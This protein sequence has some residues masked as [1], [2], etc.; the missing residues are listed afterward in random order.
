MELP[1]LI[2]SLSTADQGRNRNVF[3]VCAAE[4]NDVHTDLVWGDF[5]NC[6]LLILTQFK[7]VNS[8]TK[9]DKSDLTVPDCNKESIYDIKFLLGAGSLND[10]LVAR[11][12]VENLKINKTFYLFSCLKDYSV[13]TLK[14]LKDICLDNFNIA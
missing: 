1:D 6:S 2:N 12:M 3:K 13:D 8:L 10:E 9:V 5:D 14:A 11:F 4:I 7:K